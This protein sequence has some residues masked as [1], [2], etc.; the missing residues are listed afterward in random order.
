MKNLRLNDNEVVEVAR[1]QQKIDSYEGFIKAL[2]MMAKS[3]KDINYPLFD[4]T[5]LIQ[6]MNEL[7][8]FVRK[9]IKENAEKKINTLQI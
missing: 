7:W 5:D 9:N 8:R 2:F 1:M 4:G 6:E 3:G